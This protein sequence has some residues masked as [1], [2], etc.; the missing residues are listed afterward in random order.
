MV[1]NASKGIGQSGAK[2]GILFGQG[3][4]R[5]GPPVIIYKT[6]EPVEDFVPIRLSDDHKEIVFYPDPSDLAK[7]T[8]LG[9]PVK[10]LKNYWLGKGGISKNTAF[11][12]IT[13]SEYVKLKG[14]LS[15]SVMKSKIMSSV[16]FEKIWIGPVFNPKIH[17]KAWADSLVK[18]W[19][20]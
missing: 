6:N 4:T 18:L 7:T 19:K 13:R 2:P 1:A 10:L 15:E 20:D 17:T 14:P 11:L 8:S 9:K 16:K 3:L 12:N 5:K